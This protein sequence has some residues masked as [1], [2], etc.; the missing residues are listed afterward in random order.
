MQSWDPRAWI[1]YGNSKVLLLVKCVWSSYESAPR[2]EPDGLFLWSSLAAKVLQSV[3]PSHCPFPRCP[4]PWRYPSF[5]LGC[6][7]HRGQSD[8]NSFVGLDW[9]VPQ[10]HSL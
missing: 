4:W 10:G 8:K 2:A 1:G 6:P 7:Q 3:P 5:L 9:K